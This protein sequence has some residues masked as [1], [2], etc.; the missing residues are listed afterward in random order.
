MRSDKR[1]F[2]DDGDLEIADLS[3]APDAL[4]YVLIVVGDRLLQV[5][6][7][8][9]IGRTGTDKDDVHLDLFA[10]GHKEKV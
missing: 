10:F 2:F 6:R 3:P 5:K 7:G 8:G 4:F 1:A 9:Q